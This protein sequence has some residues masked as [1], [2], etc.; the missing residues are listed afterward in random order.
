MAKSKWSEREAE[1]ARIKLEIEELKKTIGEAVDQLKT[2]D[3]A[4]EGERMHNSR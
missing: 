4:I 1:E 3:E 2:C